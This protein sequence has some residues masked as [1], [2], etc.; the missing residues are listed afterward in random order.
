[1]AMTD[2]LL[3]RM[4]ADADAP[5]VWAAADATGQ[6][7]S[8]PSSDTG[9]SLHT[10][11]TGRRVALLVPGAEVS[12]FQVALPAGNEARQL[13]LAPFALEDQVSEDVELLHFSVGARD[14]LTG[15]TPVAVV[16]RNRM[17]Q[18]LARAT[19]LQLIPQA[20][21]AESDLAPVLPGHVTMVVADEHLLLRN[22]TAR[23]LLLPAA[24]PELALDMLLGDEIDLATVHLAV[25]ASP[26]DWARH[27][28]AVEVLRE[29][30][31]SYKVQLSAGAPLAL[32]AQGLAHSTP[33]SLLQGGFRPQKA[34]GATWRQWRPAAALAAALLLLHGVGSWWQLRQ[35]RRAS[36][37][38][39]QSIAVLYGSIFPGQPPGPEPRRRLERRLASVSGDANQQGELMHLLAAVA[40]ARQN[41]PVAQL[42]SFTFKPGSMQMK[43]TAPDATTLEQFSKALGASGY[44]AQVTGGSVRGEV[45]E[46]QVE[47]RNPG[48]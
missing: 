22:D 47:V 20:V 34:S 33:I 8:L 15:L 5:I 26:D 32:F 2:W 11:S 27:A 19:S 9:G 29:R 35:M 24:D 10:L 14:A 13:Q 45:Y 31:A 48:S 25:Y 36:A 46:G 41:V 21:F 40:A 7:L 42:Q 44:T 17:Q 16:A 30:V 18:W 1:M 37:E 43:L 28:A 39:E 4:P 23:P 38:A 12:Q 3:L 6:L